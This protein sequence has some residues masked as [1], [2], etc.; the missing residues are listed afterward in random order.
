M[1]YLAKNELDYARLGVS[2][3]KACGNAVVRNRLKRLFREVFRKNQTQIPAGFDYLIIV[4]ASR[5]NNAKPS[6]FDFKSVKMSFL[7]LVRKIIDKIE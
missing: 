1:L 4:S 5:K 3:G 2:V 7:K 6:D